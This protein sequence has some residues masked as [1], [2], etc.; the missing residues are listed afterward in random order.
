MALESKILE[1]KNLPAIFPL[2]GLLLTLYYVWGVLDFIWFH[3]LRPK[4]WTRLLHGTRPYALITGATDGIGRSAAKELYAK[5]FN[6]ILHG[7]SGEKMRRTVEEVKAVNPTGGLDVKYFITDVG[8]LDI[9]FG[10]IA[11]Q[12][13]GLNI[14]LFVNNVGASFP[15]NKMIDRSDEDFI[16]NILNINT[17]FPFFITRAFLPYLRRNS[18]SGPVEVVFI[19]SIAGDVTVPFVSPYA[20]SKALTK[21]VSRILH[22]DERVLSKSNLS[23]VYA[24]VGVVQT[25]SLRVGTSLAQP[26]S[27]D[28]ARH[29][30]ESFGSGRRVVIPHP[31]HHVLY[32][33]VTGMPEAL[34][35]YIV[36]AEARS[37][38]REIE[39]DKKKG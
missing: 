27:D 2:L 13:E 35:D 32:A 9:D 16:T 6:L 12:F 7:R 22:A 21:R 18:Q 26:H 24:N 20:G 30:V 33:I 23:F 10:A 1:L 29:L 39:E 15:T 11:G 17:R 25:G 19:G 34:C 3:Y 31:V 8:R 4:S 38:F 37:L 28:Y 36:S 5:G 14:T